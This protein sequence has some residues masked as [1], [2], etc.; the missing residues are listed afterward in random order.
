MKNL[1]SNSHP[2]TLHLAEVIWLM[3]SSFPAVEHGPLYYRS[4]DIEKIESLRQLK[5]I[6]LV[7]YL[8]LLIQE[9]NCSGGLQT[10]FFPVK[11]SH[12]V[13]LI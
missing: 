3:V 6:S 9:R 11:Q 4:L 10:Y 12:M 1:L 7:K 5:A 2:T 8:Y 13:K